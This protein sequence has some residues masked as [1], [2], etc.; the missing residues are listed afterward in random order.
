MSLL[1]KETTF[2]GLIRIV[3]LKM[4]LNWS[5]FWSTTL[6]S[7]FIFILI[8]TNNFNKL[9]LALERI[10]EILVGASASIFTIVLAALAIIIATFNKKILPRLL[11]SKLLHKFLFPF[12]KAMVLWGFSILAGLTIIVLYEMEIYKFLDYTLIFNLYIFIYSL[13]YTIGLTGHV[14]RHVLQSSQT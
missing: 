7:A 1:Y 13:F 8:S 10:P 3:G 6:M 14:I 4:I 2:L 12:W 11:L 9:N 5:F